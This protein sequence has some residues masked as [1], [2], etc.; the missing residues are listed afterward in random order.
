MVCAGC[1]GGFLDFAVWF[2]FLWAVII[3]F[4]GFA[5]L[6]GFWVCVVCGWFGVG[7]LVG[8]VVVV[9]ILVADLGCGFFLFLWV[10]RVVALCFG[11]WLRL[12]FLWC[13]CC[14]AW[15]GW[16]VFLGWDLL[17][18]LRFWASSSS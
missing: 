16:A 5:V 12:W 18:E 17:L 1:L 6:L 8:F 10:L 14:A 4:L 13:G 3:W 9:L 7:Y 2:G 11:F 15:F